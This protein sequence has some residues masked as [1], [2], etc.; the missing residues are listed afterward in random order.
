MD[1]GDNRIHEHRGGF[2]AEATGGERF[3]G[4]AGMAPFRPEGFGE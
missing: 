3:D 2:R 4:L 1:A